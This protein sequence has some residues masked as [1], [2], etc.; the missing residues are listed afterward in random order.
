[1]N[2]ERIAQQMRDLQIHQ[3]EVELARL[4]ASLGEP[5]AGPLMVALE[6]IAEQAQIVEA[7]VTPNPVSEVRKWDGQRGWTLVVFRERPISESQTE[8]ADLVFD[9]QGDGVGLLIDL[10]C[11]SEHALELAEAMATGIRVLP[12]P[13]SPDSQSTHASNTP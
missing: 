12:A 8:I 7:Y 6:R 5:L 2:V 9:A 1:M 13:T 10:L 3:L 11:W 4:K